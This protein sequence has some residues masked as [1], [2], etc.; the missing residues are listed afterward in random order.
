MEATPPREKIIELRFDRGMTRE[1]I[2]EHFDVSI[3]TV[4]RWIKELNVPRPSRRSRTKRP[5]HLTS[6]GEIVAKVGDAY[7]KL[8]RARMT[9][10]GRVVE[11]AGR[12]YYLDGKPASADEIIEAAQ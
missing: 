8:E 3:A 1:D 5:K 11:R 2:A 7:N 9:L 6:S 4:R 10:E 12:G